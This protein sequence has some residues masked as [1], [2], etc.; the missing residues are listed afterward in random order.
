MDENS[1][2][3]GV[4]FGQRVSCNYSSVENERET[5]RC[6]HT[7]NT[8]EYA[9]VRYKCF[10]DHWTFVIPIR[11]YE[12]QSCVKVNTLIEQHPQN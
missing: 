1:S 8:R 9:V 6:L 2:A 4:G 7:L 12:N 3:C 11:E 5:L 10:S